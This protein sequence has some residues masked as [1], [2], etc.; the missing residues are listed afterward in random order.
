MFSHIMIGSNDIDRSK[1]FYDANPK[2]SEAVYAAVI[3]ANDFINKKPGEA[4]EIYIKTTSEKRSSQ[5]EMAKFISDP[6]NI[7]TTTPQQ[8]AFGQTF[9]FAT[10]A[11]QATGAKAELS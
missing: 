10:L 6:D 7:W 5:S 9:K 11:A 8:N 2:V 3:E 1:K 4:A